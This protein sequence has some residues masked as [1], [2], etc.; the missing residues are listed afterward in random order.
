MKY[1]N[2]FRNGELAQRVD[3]DYVPVS[4]YSYYHANPLGN[5][6]QEQIETALPTAQVMTKSIANSR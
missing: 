1:L 2:E 6:M 5:L 3:L 4:H